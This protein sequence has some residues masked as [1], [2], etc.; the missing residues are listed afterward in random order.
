MNSV[1]SGDQLH[2]ALKG[3]IIS[4]MVV[5]K[6]LVL[7]LSIN[8][9]KSHYVYLETQAIPFKTPTLLSQ[10]S[11]KAWLS[12]CEGFGSYHFVTQSIESKLTPRNMKDDLCI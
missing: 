1:T 3:N 9:I 10:L 2:M 12:F 4:L 11:H 5:S 8:H 7:Y 6:D